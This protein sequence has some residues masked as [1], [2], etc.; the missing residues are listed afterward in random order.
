MTGE[1]H[2]LIEFYLQSSRFEKIPGGETPDT[3]PAYRGGRGRGGEGIKEFLP[4]KE[5]V[6]AADGR[7]ERGGKR[8][9]WEGKGSVGSCSEVLR[10]IDAPDHGTS[11]SVSYAIT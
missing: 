8:G 11:R 3:S 6:G 5:T 7:D 1:A 10:G 2:T 9:H 4:L